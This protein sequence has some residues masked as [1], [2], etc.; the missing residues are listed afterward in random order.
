MRPG[1]R[2][3]SITGIRPVGRA[4]ASEVK[5]PPLTRYARRS[6]GARVTV[7]LAPNMVPAPRPAVDPALRSIQPLLS[8]TVLP[9][10]SRGRRVTTLTAPV[11]AFAP[12][13][14]DAGPRTTSICSMSPAFV[15][16]R[17]H[18]TMPKK[19]R[20]TLR[21]STS[22]S[23]ELA[24]VPVDC[25]L[26]TLTS[27]AES[28]TTLTP[29]TERSASPTL[30]DAAVA[31]VVAG[32]TDVVTGASTT[33][34]SVRDAVTTTVSPKL[35][36]DSVTA[37]TS[38]GAPATTTSSTVASEKPDSDTVTAQAPSETFS[39]RYSPAPPV[40][41]ARAPSGPRN[42]TVAPGSTAPVSSMTTPRTC[43]GCAAA[44]TAPSIRR[45]M[46]IVAGCRVN[47]V[48]L[49]AV[50][51]RGAGKSGCSEVETN[52]CSSECDARAWRAAGAP[53]AG[54][55]PA[56][57]F[58]ATGRLSGGRN[59]TPPA[60]GRPASPPARPADRSFEIASQLQTI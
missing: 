8:V 14:A 55:A 32:M 7:A 41:V 3:S 5:Y 34:T 28:W 11:I 20:Y 23:C 56:A 38:T 9:T 10:D 2:G 30:V 60:A 35:A 48:V 13:V 1:S 31:R 44:G 54:S 40:P 52:E 37:G 57:L 46:P 25:R 16:T 50:V 59:L 6:L 39:N 29:G 19:S 22:T 58:D 18:S 47:G 21:P 33:R 49:R 43:P 45:I 26:V 36:S 24:S 4:N 27:R 51:C 53:G 12:H 17:S 42:V 15:G